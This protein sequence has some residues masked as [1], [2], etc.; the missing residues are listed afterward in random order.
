[1]ALTYL[2]RFMR[3]KPIHQVLDKLGMSLSKDIPISCVV[4]LGIKL[5][6]D[7]IR[8]LISLRDTVALGVNVK[9]R[10]KKRLYIAGRG[11]RIGDYSYID[12][13]SSNGVTL[14]ANF[15]LGP[16]SRI[17]ASGTLTVL[18]VGLRTESGVSFGDHAHIGCAGGIFIGR[19]NI[20]VFKYSC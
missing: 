1:M 13:L 17:I 8:G 11:I 7:Y 2:S 14:G 4:D 10:A 16:F 18:G 6:F 9:I 19:Y 20:W 3:S 15:R 5:F 12:C